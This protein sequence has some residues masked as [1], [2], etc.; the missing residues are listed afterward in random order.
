MVSWSYSVVIGN[1][2]IYILKSLNCRMHILIV[3]MPRN[4]SWIWQKKR[5]FDENEE[6]YGKNI[7]KLEK[8]KV[9]IFFNQ[10]NNHK[11]FKL[12]FKS[13][14]LE[15]EKFC[16]EMPPQ[17]ILEIGLCRFWLHRSC[18]GLAFLASLHAYGCPM[19]LL[20]DCNGF[21]EVTSHKQHEEICPRGR[22]G[23]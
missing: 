15:S 1:K 10:N 21:W 18:N 20:G 4:C 3:K 7:G 16:F 12:N 22:F 13:F 14:Q 8:K 2:F 19:G 5:N 17:C 11:I 6:K 23:Q 9:D